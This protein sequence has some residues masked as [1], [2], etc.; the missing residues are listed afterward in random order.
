[1]RNNKLQQGFTMIE[2][3]VVIAILGI[4]AAFV[5]PRL[6]DLTDDAHRANVQATRGALTSA[7]NL[8]QAQWV[9]KGKPGAVVNLAGFG[10]GNVDVSIDGWPVGT[11]D[12]VTTAMTS[13]RCVEIW[14][15]LLVQQ[16]PDVSAALADNPDYL[17][18]ANGTVCTYTYQNSPTPTRTITYDVAT[19]EVGGLD[20]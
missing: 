15:G 8:V 9:A 17:A 14:Q 11:G 16:A 18:S 2:L 20:G 13:A 4:L 12:S 19:G 3:V 6:A 10:A 7:V 5:L 1:M